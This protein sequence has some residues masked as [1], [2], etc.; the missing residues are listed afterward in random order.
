M[1]AEVQPL[2]RENSVSKFERLLPHAELIASLASG[3]LI[4]AGWL[5]SRD[6]QSS[7]SVALFLSAFFIGGFAKAKEGIEA[8]IRDKELNVE[9]LMIFAAI[10]SAIIGYWAE[11]AILIFIFSLSGALETYTMNKSRKEI[12]A[13]MDIQPESAVRITDAGEEQVH[14]SELEVGDLVRVKPGERIPTD[15]LIEKG[16]T[17]ID[18]S[19]ITGESMPVSK[20]AGNEAFTG[21]VNVSGSLTIQVTKPSSETLFQKIID[22]VQSAQSEKSPSQL[23]IE[24]FEGTYVKAVLLVVLLMM[25]LPHYVLGWSW[26]ETFYRAMILLVVASP[27]A[28][29]ASIMPASLAAISNGARKGILFKGGVHLENLSRMSTV[30]FDKTGTLT[31]GRPEVTD[32]IPK[33]GLDPDKVMR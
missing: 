4:L 3:V 20:Q 33:D 7:V 26:N 9:L 21:T 23:F 16:F 5:A 29:V 13:L 12:S 1:M 15:G 18:E 19:A 25:F 27:C 30:I 10:G 8:T 14:I 28:L 31:R 17:T 11:G 2:K 32:F 6:S 22:L 24:R